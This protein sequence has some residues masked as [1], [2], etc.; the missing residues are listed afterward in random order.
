MWPCLLPCASQEILQDD[1][2]LKKNFLAE[3]RN[4]HSVHEQ[5]S[6]KKEICNGEYCELSHSR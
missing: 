3:A 5:A 1:D 6:E 4:G 2:E